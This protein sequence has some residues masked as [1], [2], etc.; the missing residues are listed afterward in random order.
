MKERENQS[1]ILIPKPISPLS[2][3]STI[4]P[5]FDVVAEYLKELKHNSSAV[6]TRLALTKLLQ[7]TTESTVLGLRQE[8]EHTI[9]K[10]N[11]SV[12][13]IS[14]RPVCD[15][16]KIELGNQMKQGEDF[17]TTIKHMIERGIKN[18][19][20]TKQAIN[21]ITLESERFFSEGMRI[22]TYSYSRVVLECLY[23]ARRRCNISVAVLCGGP[24]EDGKRMT[25]E[26]QKRKIITTFVPDSAM[27]AVIAD[28]DMVLVGARAV[29]ENGGIIAKMGTRTVATVAHEFNVNFF[30]AAESYKFA[31]LFPLSQHHLERIAPIRGIP[32]D[33]KNLPPGTPVYSPELD[34]T[35][36]N[37]I[38]NL[39]T[40]LGLLTPSDV[41]EELFVL[42]NA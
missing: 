29:T 32:I 3:D 40:D 37:Y 17:Q 1:E 8:L 27:S 5:E 13:D 14:V 16:F 34:Y 9:Q 25:T 12:K 20:L 18:K 10:L 30:V 36:P 4:I 39:W 6:A 41:S 38:R 23:T 15:L 26:L 2:K 42:Y 7:L 35:P 21:K 22:V 31:K 28:A 19:N 24:D 11:E 33:K